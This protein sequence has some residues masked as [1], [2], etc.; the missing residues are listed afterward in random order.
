MRL[1]F[2]VSV[3]FVMQPQWTQQTAFCAQAEFAFCFLIREHFYTGD[4]ND[5]EQVSRMQEL[6]V[7]LYV[8]CNNRQIIMDTGTALAHFD[9]LVAYYEDILRLT[10]LH[11]YK[12]QA[13]YFWARPVILDRA[14]NQ[15]LVS[16]PWYDTVSELDQLCQNLQKTTEGRCFYDADQGWS[17]EIEHYNNRLFIQ[18]CDPDEGEIYC[19]LSMDRQPIVE[20]V[21][22]VQ[23]QA[24]QVVAQLV[25]HFHKDYWSKHWY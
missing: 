17:L 23:E 10:R 5:S 16:F 25:K 19:L 13:H 4:P 3:E 15:A 21:Q 6:S 24:H 9:Q 8:P 14:E 22:Q 11:Q 12:L 2:F 1:P 18:E 20:Q 7:P